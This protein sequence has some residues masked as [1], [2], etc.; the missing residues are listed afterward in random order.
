M[1]SVYDCLVPFGDKSMETSLRVYI[2]C[3]S[4]L[5]D[6]ITVLRTLMPPIVTGLSACLSP[7]EP[8]HG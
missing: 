8:R 6:H 7:S 3:S 2:C 1:S 5:L 4:N